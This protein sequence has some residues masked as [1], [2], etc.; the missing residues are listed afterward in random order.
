MVLLKFGDIIIRR[1]L[2]NE[3]DKC[4]LFMKIKMILFIYYVS[5]NNYSKFRDH[6]LSLNPSYMK[7]LVDSLRSIEN[8]MGKE[9]KILQPGE[10]KSILSMRRSLYLSKN[11]ADLEGICCHA[12]SCYGIKLR[13]WR[14]IAGRGVDEHI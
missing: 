10:K 12:I 7:R 13:I 11:I 5:Y 1:L 3:T 14:D 9:E 8:M 6:R 4:A 2:L